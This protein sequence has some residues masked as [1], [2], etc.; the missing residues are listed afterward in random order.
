MTHEISAWFFSSDGV[1]GFDGAWDV[2]V[3]SAPGS[4]FVSTALHAMFSLVMRSAWDRLSVDCRNHCAIGASRGWPNVPWVTSGVVDGSFIDTTVSNLS[5]GTEYVS[6]A[7]CFSYARARVMTCV[8][9]GPA[10]GCS[11]GCWMMTRVTPQS[12]AFANP[13]TSA[14]HARPCTLRQ[15]V[16]VQGRAR[17]ISIVVVWFNQKTLEKMYA[18]GVTRIARSLSCWSAALNQDKLHRIIKDDW[19]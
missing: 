8:S 3:C 1:S 4:C 18:V 7:A 9:R 2:C 12:I 11:G 6:L 15:A 10:G 16:H 5:F 13:K 19:I 14:R 17:W